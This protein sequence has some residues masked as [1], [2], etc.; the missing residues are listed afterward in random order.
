MIVF[1][2]LNDHQIIFLRI[3]FIFLTIFILPELRYEKILC[4]S[5]QLNGAER[6]IFSILPMPVIHGKYSLICCWLR[7]LSTPTH[8]ALCQCKLPLMIVLGCVN[9]KKN[10]KKIIPGQA[11]HLFYGKKSHLT[12]I[13]RC[14]HRDNWR[15]FISQMKVGS[16]CC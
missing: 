7:F 9:K 12:R 4:Y 5:V 16:S 13:L 3:L 10:V 11:D 8:V 2:K 1:Y 6:A 15:Q 14:S